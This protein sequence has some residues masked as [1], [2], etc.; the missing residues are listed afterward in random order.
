M[1]VVDQEVN[2]NLNETYHGKKYLCSIFCM[3]TAKGQ[4][5]FIQFLLHLKT[6]FTVGDFNIV[7]YFLA[8]FISYVKRQVRYRLYD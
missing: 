4:K 5:L 7:I 1:C 6:A 2:K 8:N 3:P